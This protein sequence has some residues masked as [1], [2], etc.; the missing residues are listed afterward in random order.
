MIRHVLHDSVDEVTNLVMFFWSI[1]SRRNRYH[2][3]IVTC[4]LSALWHVMMRAHDSKCIF[5]GR[6][7]NSIISIRLL[8]LMMV[9]SCYLLTAVISVRLLLFL[10]VVM[11]GRFSLWLIVCIRSRL[12]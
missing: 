2:R 6:S 11:V 8:S 1:H 9:I 3:K 12:G 5:M 7:S 10:R 4:G